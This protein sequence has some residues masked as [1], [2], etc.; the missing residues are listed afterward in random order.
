M[1]VVAQFS[2]DIEVNRVN[3]KPREGGRM[4]SITADATH[5]SHC[6]G[7]IRLI[8]CE[9]FNQIDDATNIH[10]MYG[11]VMQKRGDDKILVIFPHD[12]QYGLDILQPG[13]QCEILHQYSL[14]THSHLTVKECR[15]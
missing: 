10:G 9:I 13:K 8:D 15:R 7:Q 2:S 5:F 3:I 6:S 14:I 12:Q 11:M 4:V 1:G